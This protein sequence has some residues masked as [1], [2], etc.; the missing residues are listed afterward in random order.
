MAQKNHWYVRRG[1]QV[2]GPFLAA[3]ITQYLLLGR[4]LDDD[5]LSQN[6][7]DWQPAISHK[8]L[9]PAVMLEDPRDEEKIQAERLK[10]DER[11]KDRRAPKDKD[12]QGERRKARDRRQEE[13]EDIVEYRQRH[14]K[15]IDSLQQDTSSRM[16]GRLFIY[17]AT[18]LIVLLGLGLQLSPDQAPA[19]ADCSIAAAPGINWKNCAKPGIDVSGKNLSQANLNNAKL[20]LAKFLG[21]KLISADLSYAE[22]QAS[23]FANANLTGARLK[24]ANLT[25]ADLTYANFSN[26]DLSFADLSDADIGGINLKN[27]R[28]NNTIWIDKRLCAAGSVGKCSSD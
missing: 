25:Q 19:K 8:Q 12:M 24:G 11:A 21:T 9:Y 4:V 7:Q 14:T 22:L 10:I 27:A 23:S 1:D 2:K 5:E 28:L 15:V 17:L 3:H 18:V 26:A 20:S 13:P 16:N 6:Q